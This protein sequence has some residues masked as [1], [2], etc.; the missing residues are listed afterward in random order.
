VRWLAAWGKAVVDFFWGP[1]DPRTYALV[2]ISLSVAGL[3]NVIHLWPHRHEYL[4]STGMISTDAIRDATRGGLYGSV[5]YWI[6]SETGVTLV[7]LGAAVALLAL[8]VGLWSR[9]SALLVFVW[10]LSYSDRA[11]PILHGWDAILRVYSFLLLVSPMGRAWSVGRLLD[12]DAKEEK[13]LPLYGL[14]LMQWQLF[15]IYLTT[16]WLK[17][18]DPFWRNG[19]V[20]SYFSVSV[21]SRSPSDLFLVHHEWISAIGT[22]LTLIVETS[23]PWLLWFRKTR[24]VGI[25]AGFGLHFVI[26]ATAKLTVFSL[27]MIPA[28]MSFLEREDIDRILA[29]GE[30]QLRRLRKMRS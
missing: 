17:V 24:F 4:A 3:A 7:C 8:G 25:F 27:A 28:Y 13:G 15:V 22:Y 18:P 21:F 16:V 29:L 9:A 11:F 10:H 5:F 23:L 20:L 2:R 26:A 30:A 6:S 1:A 14:R 19:Q 12:R